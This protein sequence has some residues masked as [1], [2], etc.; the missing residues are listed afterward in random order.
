MQIKI[1]L[2]NHSSP[3]P[4]LNAAKTHNFLLNQK[5]S[6]WTIV[7]ELVKS[8]SII[9]IVLL[10]SFYLVFHTKTPKWYLVEIFQFV[11]LKQPNI[12]L[13]YIS[14]ILKTDC[15]QLKTIN[16]ILQKESIEPIVAILY[17]N[18]CV[19]LIIIN[20]SAAHFECYMLQKKLKPQWRK[21]SKKIPILICHD[22]ILFWCYKLNKC[23]H[24]SFILKLDKKKLIYWL[25]RVFVFV[26]I[27]ERST[28]FFMIEKQGQE[29]TWHPVIMCTTDC[30]TC[31]TE[32][33]LANQCHIGTK[34]RKLSGKTW[35]QCKV[36]N[37]LVYL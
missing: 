21:R 34:E 35:R 1:L 8:D 19:F 23:I 16:Y 31:T 36:R 17:I 22:K 3:T 6:S 28:F 27:H 13:V 37:Y 11:F 24:L 26:L 32:L 30:V 33:L 25:D 5:L 2:F 7:K 14:K 20:P 9:V 4:P 18:R 15:F 29:K 10:F 12:I